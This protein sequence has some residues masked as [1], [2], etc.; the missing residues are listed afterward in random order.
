[1]G[2]CGS[3]STKIKDQD[4][5]MSVDQS[6]NSTVTNGTLGLK[7]MEKL[8]SFSGDDCDVFDNN[9]ESLY[10]VTGQF[11]FIGK[12]I[13]L[14]DRSGKVVVILDKPAVAVHTEFTVYSHINNGNETK[15]FDGEAFYQ[16]AL[17]QKTVLLNAYTYYLYDTKGEKRAHFKLTAPLI[18]ARMQYE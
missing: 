11:Q 14:K 2:V 10:K 7:V 9:N 18:S 16:H 5:G 12:T 17:I 8:Y 15:D 3:R 4:G 13:K 1:M 6:L